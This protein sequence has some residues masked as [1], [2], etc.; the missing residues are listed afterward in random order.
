M[1]IKENLKARRKELD[2]TLEE[3]A[4][5][6]GVKRST[7]Q[8][9]ESGMIANIPSDKIVKLAEI[10]HTTPAQLMGWDDATYP[11]TDPYPDNDQE[12]QDNFVYTY[13][14]HEDIL[15]I[16]KH[17][18]PMLGEIACGPLSLCEPTF[19]GYVEA[20]V[21]VRADFCI[22]AR[23]DSMINA[24][25]HNGDIVF[26][27]AQEDVEDGEIAA[28]LIED[29]TTLKRVFRHGDILQLQAENP[30]V[31]PIICRAE[32]HL[33]IRILGKAVAFQ[34]DII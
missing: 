21:A 1:G 17:R 10:Y 30:K 32:D 27:R 28:V 9:Y 20:G 16:S 2:L 33:N 8:R 5:R 11:E 13:G 3:A 29:E 26:I 7:L 18:F 34:S 12:Q 14:H 19:E 15:P 4:N 23:G 24:R 25:I 6:L 22:R 31:K